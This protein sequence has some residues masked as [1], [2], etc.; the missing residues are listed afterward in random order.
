MLSRSLK[1]TSRVSSV[2][3]RSGALRAFSAAGAT[4]AP[5]AAPATGDAKLQAKVD[6]INKDAA[7]AA[8]QKGFL[9]KMKEYG[10]PGIVTY[11]SLYATNMAVVYAG[12]AAT[13][14][15]DYLLHAIESIDVGIIQDLVK[16]TKEEF[17]SSANL[18]ST[19]LITDLCE[20]IR[21][22]LT[23]VLAKKWISY[24]KLRDAVAAEAVPPIYA[25]TSNPNMPATKEEKANR[26]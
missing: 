10:V 3:A 22:P 21:L 26:I 20:P 5:V 19:V 11:A 14:T 8:A 4:A 17:P 13:G 16:M 15:G 2:A 24:R 25:H 12:V 7:D 9:G 1:L 23:F 6:A 18:I